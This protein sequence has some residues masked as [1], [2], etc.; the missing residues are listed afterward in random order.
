MIASLRLNC[1]GLER[2]ALIHLLAFTL[3]AL[4]GC[5]HKQTEEKYSP[6]YLA[7]KERFDQIDEEMTEEQVDAIM[8]GYRSFS[9]KE[10]TKFGGHGPP[11]KRI[12]TRTKWYSEA[13]WTEWEYIL[14]VYFDKDGYTVGKDI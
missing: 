8:A 5:E 11:F 10:V 9:V 3:L 14:H 12:S 6:E 1:L 7:I 4:A 13:A 2:F